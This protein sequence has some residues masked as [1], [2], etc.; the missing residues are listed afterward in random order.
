V[1]DMVAAGLKHR[2]CTRRKVPL[3]GCVLC[4]PGR[5]R[6]ARRVCIDGGREAPRGDRDS[7]VGRTRRV[8]RSS[9]GISLA[10]S[11]M[12]LY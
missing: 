4:H 11:V 1:R 2:P 9:G 12:N 10:L 5:S 7:G 3:W 6:L 8:A